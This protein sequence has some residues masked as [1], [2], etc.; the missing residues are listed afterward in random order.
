VQVQGVAGTFAATIRSLR[1]D[2]AFTPY[3]A[4]TGDDAS[5]LAYRAELVL[6]GDAATKLPA[7]LPVEAEC[8]AHDG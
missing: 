2:P 6:E 7:G 8:D 5:R 4:L 3:F 1:S